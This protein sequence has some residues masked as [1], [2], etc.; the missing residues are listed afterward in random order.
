MAG[1]LGRTIDLE[2]HAFFILFIAIVLMI[3][4][5]AVWELLSELTDYIHEKYGIKRVY[6]YLISLLGVMLL[7][8]I[9]PQILEK[10]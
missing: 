9:F 2:K 3:F 4:W 6:V 1:S 7:I 5:H 8:G 10:I